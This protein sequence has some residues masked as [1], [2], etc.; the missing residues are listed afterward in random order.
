MDLL[1][2]LKRLWFPQGPG[3]AK[4]WNRPWTSWHVPMEGSSTIERMCERRKES[5]YIAILCEQCCDWCVELESS[6][7]VQRRG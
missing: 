7:S 2:H 5:T 6:I 3:I 4:P 1:A